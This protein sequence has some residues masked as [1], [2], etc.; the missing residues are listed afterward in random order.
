M[1]KTWPGAITKLHFVFGITTSWTKFSGNDSM[2]TSSKVVAAGFAATRRGLFEGD[3][4][5]MSPTPDP[6][7]ASRCH[8]V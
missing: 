3:Y 7:G 4:V 6:G 5:T 1:Y 8:F 2:L